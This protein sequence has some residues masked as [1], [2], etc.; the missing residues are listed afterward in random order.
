VGLL[1]IALDLA[2]AWILRRWALERLG[3]VRAE[4]AAALWLCLPAPFFLGLRG[5]EAALATSSVLLC[6]WLAT[7]AQRPPAWQLG[8][9]LGLAGLARIDHLI[10]LGLSLSLLIALQRELPLRLRLRHLALVALLSATIVAPWFAW[11]RLEFGSFLPVSGQVKL[12]TDRIVSALPHDYSRPSAALYSSLHAVAAPV[13]SC[14]RWLCGE[15]F[16]SMR[17][18]WGAIGLSLLCGGFLIW[19]GTREWIRRAGSCTLWGALAFACVH[20]VLFGLIWHSYSVWYAHPLLALSCLALA[21]LPRAGR[22]WASSA[23]LVGFVILQLGLGLGYAL[24]VAHGARGAESAW[25]A[26][27]DRVLQV[28][29]AGGRIGAWDAGAAG[30]VALLY[31]QITIVN[32][33]GLV[34]NRGAFDAVRAGRYGEYLLSE[35][36]YLIQPPQRARMYLQGEELTRFLEAYRARSGPG[37]DN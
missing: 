29:P 23:A 28:A 8:L 30:Y 18:S 36:D 35:L 19:Q 26:R 14:A 27:F 1:Q 4:W 11:C 21:A 25:R 2:S 16:T 22:S 17:W 12:Y 5:M 6:L 33:D 34:N 20:Q 3:K 15:E 9:A 13:V 24:R 7:R 31:P 37:L 10:S 32:L